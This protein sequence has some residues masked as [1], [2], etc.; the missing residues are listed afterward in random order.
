MGTLQLAAIAACCAPDAV[1]EAA[2]E[3][4]R[5]AELRGQM[6]NALK[7]VGIDVVDGQAPFVLFSTPAPRCCVSTCNAS[8]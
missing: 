3:A 2:A 5:L 7:S 6:A 8:R 4:L 1:A